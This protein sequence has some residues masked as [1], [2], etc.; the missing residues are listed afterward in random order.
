MSQPETYDFD[1]YIGDSWPSGIPEAE[2]L[3]TISYQSSTVDLDSALS[4]TAEIKTAKSDDTAIGSFTVDVK[5]QST[6]EGEVGLTLGADVTEL[7]DARQ[8]YWD[9]QVNWSTTENMTVLAGL[10][11]AI[12][13]VTR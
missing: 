6:N 1:V 3:V 10:V 4:V 11:T 12:G 2:F 5:D 7:L 13:D 8:Y 9:L